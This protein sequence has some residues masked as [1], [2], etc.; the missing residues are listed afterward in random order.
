MHC[1]WL[2]NNHLGGVEQCWMSTCTPS[3]VTF[4]VQN[5]MCF[6]T[7]RRHVCLV[8]LSMFILYVRLCARWRDCH[9]SRLRRCRES[10]AEWRTQVEVWESAAKIRKLQHQ[11]DRQSAKQ[12]WVIRRGTEK[13]P[14]FQQAKR[15]CF[16]TDC[17]TPASPCG[18]FCSCD[19][20]TKL[21]TPKDASG[22]FLT[23]TWLEI[24][25][26]LFVCSIVLPKI[27]H[28][29]F[30][31]QNRWECGG[32]FAQRSWDLKMWDPLPALV[33]TRL[34]VDNSS[35]WTKCKKR[36]KDKKKAHN[37]RSLGHSLSLH[38]QSSKLV[39][40]HLQQN[41][42]AEIVASFNIG[43]RCRN[44]QK[45]SWF[46]EISWN[47]NGSCFSERKMAGLGELI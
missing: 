33:C 40:F 18:R 43:S 31:S 17:S 30:L 12:E 24:A 21:G 27:A 15:C 38:W 35:I 7:V 28:S 5:V 42:T 46:V 34:L 6:S 2:Q 36:G 44:I 32:S 39:Q 25:H 10:C 8:C 41:S 23:G 13:L 29:Q 9:L 14:F 26:S 20:M 37:G 1:G 16:Q 11:W 19:K 3:D 4:I 22:I 47:W 45:A